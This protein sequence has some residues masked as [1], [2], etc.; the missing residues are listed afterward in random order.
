M[1]M[2]TPSSIL[3][4][5]SP[6]TEE[7][8]R[9]QSMGL[10]RIG[11]DWGT[12]THMPGEGKSK[13][14]KLITNTKPQCYNAWKASRVKLN[15]NKGK[16]S[17]SHLHNKVL[18]S[19]GKDCYSIIP[20]RGRAFLPLQPSVVFLCQLSREIINRSQNITE[21]DWEESCPWKAEV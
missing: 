5:W 19:R 2:V 14:L 9:L 13:S 16:N 8:G 3:A 1:G 10:Q 20:V 17:L 4:W 21:M 11:Q 12:N 6:W 18:L 7:P 15:K